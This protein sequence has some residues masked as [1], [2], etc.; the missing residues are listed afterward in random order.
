M[1]IISEDLWQIFYPLEHRYI[2]VNN[3]ILAYFSFINFLE[4]KIKD[5]KFYN[6]KCTH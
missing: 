1:I 4:V 6:Y 5:R 3:S 2:R